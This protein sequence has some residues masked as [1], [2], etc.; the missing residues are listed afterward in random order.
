MSD[1]WMKLGA[2][3]CLSDFSYGLICLFVNCSVEFGLL[4]ADWRMFENPEAEELI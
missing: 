1:F 4:L 3:P 2:F